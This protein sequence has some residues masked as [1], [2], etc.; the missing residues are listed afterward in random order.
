MDQEQAWRPIGEPEA[1]RLLAAL[2]EPKE[3]AER[4]RAG[5]VAGRPRQMAENRGRRVAAGAI[6]LAG[7]GAL[8]LWWIPPHGAPTRA[9]LPGTGTPG[10]AASARAGDAPGAIQEPDVNKRIAAAVVS[11]AAMAG[12]AGAQSAVQWRVEDGGNGHWY[13]G[14]AM[15]DPIA[16]SAARSQAKSRGG[17][18][19]CVATSAEDLWVYEHVASA[20][21]MWSNVDI[22]RVGPWLGARGKGGS[23]GWIDGSV[24][25]YS[26]FYPGEGTPT[27]VEQFAHYYAGISQ[28][29]QGQQWADYPDGTI[30][31]SF[32]VEWSADCNNDG[33]VDYGQCRDGSMWDGNANNVPDCCEQ[34]VPC[35]V[36]DNPVQWRTE[37]GGNGHWYQG[38]V[39]ASGGY[40]RAAAL[41]AARAR[42]GDLV[43]LGS[44]AERDFIAARALNHPR[45]WVRDGGTTYGPWSGAFMDATCNWTWS[46]GS[47]FA[48][49][50]WAFGEP[51]SGCGWAGDNYG[52][53]ACKSCGDIASLPAQFVDLGAGNALAPGLL[54]E[55]SAD[56]NN[57]GIVDFGQIRDGS[58]ADTNANGIPDTCECAGADI[59][60]N[61][62][63]D[64][65]D[66]GA[67]LAF[68]GPAG[69]VL[70][71]ADL[72]RDGIV[73]GEDLGILLANWGPCGG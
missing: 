17:D 67:L 27:A 23:W 29:G 19:A 25:A 63:V 52:C 57:D 2:V 41:A 44:P 46:D 22:F 42:R 45:M 8:V 49:A 62:T 36:L 1:P 16:W 37:D 43:S 70:P 51:D 64:G 9:S 71:E 7:A 61:G 48:Y 24:W 72:N 54:I 65:A 20:P 73:N 4:E 59:T 33:I 68:W 50:P 60:A 21:E 30:T 18:L 47:Q 69:T 32:V 6:A 38:S 35:T 3:L 12:S 58:T 56:C 14:I 10:S 13:R 39:L 15:S 5:A 11:G 55:W 31:R 40:T 53:F 28:S 34:G 26:N 66:L